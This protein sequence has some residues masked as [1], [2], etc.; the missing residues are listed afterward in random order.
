MIGSS[1][2]T[3]L[4][5]LYLKDGGAGVDTVGIEKGNEHAVDQSRNAERIGMRSTA[6]PVNVAAIHVHRHELFGEIGEAVRTQH[7]TPFNKL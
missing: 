5:W 2:G 1:P 4:L 3:V 7:G 6:M